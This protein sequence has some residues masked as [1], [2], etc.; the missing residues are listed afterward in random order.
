M[1]V[2]QLNI[3]VFIAYNRTRSHKTKQRVEKKGQCIWE[4]FIW[5]TS[6]STGWNSLCVGG[7]A[8]VPMGLF[9][10]QS[11]VVSSDKL[12]YWPAGTWSYLQ[13]NP[14][15]VLLF[16]YVFNSFIPCEKRTPGQ[17]AAGLSCCRSNPEHPLDEIRQCQ[18]VSD[19]ECDNI[20]LLNLPK[21]HTPQLPLSILISPSMP[22]DSYNKIVV[23][24]RKQHILYVGP[25][26]ATT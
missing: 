25:S 8:A 15:R 11:V 12:S 4:S 2:W 1:F 26:T 3:D 18:W 21:T 5:V 22:S 23:V 13:K 6:H 24:I 7:L 14:T 19:D 10:H 17:T 9:L 20:F 16:V